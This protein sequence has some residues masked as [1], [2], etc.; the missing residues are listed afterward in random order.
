MRRE[1]SDVGVLFVP[2]GF[3]LVLR[4][5]RQQGGF[6]PGPSDQLQAG[7]KVGLTE[8]V[9]VSDAGNSRGVA[10]TADPAGVVTP[11]VITE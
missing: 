3:V 11:S 6:A 7:R 10:R 9:G 8:S 5:N 1:E 2:V 4:R